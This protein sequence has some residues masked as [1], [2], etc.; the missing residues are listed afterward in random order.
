MDLIRYFGN[1]LAKKINRKEMPARGL[2][3]LAI[4]LDF[5]DKDPEKLSYEDFLHL[6]NNGLKKKLEI[7]D[8]QNIDQVIKEMIAE[9]T[10]KQSLFTIGA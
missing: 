3:R 5:G 7:I 9:L 1:I 2:I 4:R 6:F 10:S 8:V